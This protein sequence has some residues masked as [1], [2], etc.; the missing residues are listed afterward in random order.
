MKKLLVVSTAIILLAAC[1]SKKK[2][3]DADGKIRDCPDTMIDNRMPRIIDENTEADAL[4]GQ[5]YIYKGER[6]EIAEFDTA[7]VNRNCDVE[8]QVVY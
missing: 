4:P 5:Y 2:A 6:R 8:V 3:H 7:W 1:T